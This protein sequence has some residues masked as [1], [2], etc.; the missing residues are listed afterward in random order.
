MTNHTGC[1]RP[2]KTL[3]TACDDCALKDDH[4]ECER[5]RMQEGLVLVERDV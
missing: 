2:N 1:S 4:M 5:T 3:Y